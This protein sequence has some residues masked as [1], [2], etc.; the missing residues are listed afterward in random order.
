[1]DNVLVEVLSLLPQKKKIRPSGAMRKAL[2]IR[3]ILRRLGSRRKKAG[4]VVPFRIFPT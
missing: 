1:M 3:S 2:S 4:M